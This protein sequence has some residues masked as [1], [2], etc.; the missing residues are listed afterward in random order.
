MR[1]HYPSHHLDC[2]PSFTLDIIMFVIAIILT[3]T[4]IKTCDVHSSCFHFVPVQLTAECTATCAF[5]L[6]HLL[7]SN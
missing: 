6:S 1:S 2:D 4:V 3:T 7:H 5:M